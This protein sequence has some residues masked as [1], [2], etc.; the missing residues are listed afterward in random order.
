MTDGLDATRNCLS[1]LFRACPIADTFA[2]CS[3][4][5][6]CRSINLIAAVAVPFATA[7]LSGCTFPISDPVMLSAIESEARSLIVDYP[8][9]AP[10]GGVDIPMRKWPPKMASLKPQVVTVHRWGVDI[11]VKPGLDGGYGY[12]VAQNQK[13]LPMPANCYS[14]LRQGVFWHAPC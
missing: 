14:K 6:M 1:T 2:M 13:D 7:F 4:S 9:S 12:A 11:M 10:D 8:I 5:A 3:T